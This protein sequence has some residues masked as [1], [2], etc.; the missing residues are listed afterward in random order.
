MSDGENPERQ[1]ETG[2]WLQGRGAT[3]GKNHTE[4]TQRWRTAARL[5]AHGEADWEGWNASRQAPYR[6]GKLKPELY[7]MCQ[8]T[9]TRQPAI[10][11][12]RARAHT[13]THAQL[14]FTEMASFSQGLVN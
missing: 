3:S 14:L 8:K 7:V 10:P 12:T 11:H 1:T 9:Q 4:R 2:R 5:S 13:H 6:P